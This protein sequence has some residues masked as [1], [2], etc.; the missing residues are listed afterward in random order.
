M[1]SIPPT[2][3]KV[4]MVSVPRELWA[5]VTRLISFLDTSFDKQTY[6]EKRKNDFDAPEDYEYC[7]NVTAN[8]ERELS[9]VALDIEKLQTTAALATPPAQECA[10]QREKNGPR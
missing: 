10:E 8:T 3:P 4:A 6:D 2:A 9:S 1:T 5:R 7:I